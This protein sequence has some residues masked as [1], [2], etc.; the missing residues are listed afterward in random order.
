MYKKYPIAFIL[1]CIFYSVLSFS[2]NTS[3]ITTYK[4]PLVILDMP[5]D[6]QDFFETA[7]ACEGW[8]SYFDIRL[9]KTTYDSVKEHIKENCSD[10]ESKLIFMKE[11]YKKNK[12]YS[13][14]LTVYYDTVLI[15][16]EYENNM[17]R[18]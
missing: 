1:I 16:K 18:E 12:D 13:E 9:E 2:K 10:I 3:G 17:R 6:L 15:Y 8:V 7:Y 14:R 11:K 5:Q 4:T